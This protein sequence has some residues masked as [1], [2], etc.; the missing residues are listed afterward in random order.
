[1][2]K[3]VLTTATFVV[4]GGAMVGAV[5]AAT[6]A[7]PPP[8]V[9]AAAKTPDFAIHLPRLRAAHLRPGGKTI[10]Y[11]ITLWSIGGYSG[12]VTLAASGLP[13]GTSGS[14]TVN[15]APL[16]TTVP[17]T[18]TSDFKLTVAQTAVPGTYPF[19][20]TATSGTLTHTV[21]TAVEI[22]P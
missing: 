11:P 17:P 21:N 13:A 22:L 18:P 19:T 15:P 5:D 2:R 7:V 9:V 16:S 12:V 14:F 20:I 10:S 6:P 1:M 8:P 4:A 3:L